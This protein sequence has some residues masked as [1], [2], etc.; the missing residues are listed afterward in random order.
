MLRWTS[1][2]FQD[3]GIDSSRLAAEVLLAHALECRRID[4]YLRFDQP[5]SGT[6]RD[7][8]RDLVRRRCQREPVAYITGRREFWSLSLAVDPGVLIPRP[9]TECL[10]EAILALLPCDGQPPRRVLDLG[11]GSGAV[12]LALASERPGYHFTATD[13]SVAALATAKFN[14]RR[15]GLAPAVQFVAGDWFAPFGAAARWDLVASNPPYIAQ[16]TLS[17]LAPEVADFEP[18]VALDGGADGLVHLAHLIQAAP[19]HLAGGGWLVLEIGHDQRAAV[20][21]LADGVGAYDPVVFGQDYGGRDR[22]ARLRR[23]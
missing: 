13:R 12:A 21:C 3:Q 16:A 18:R 2:F 20:Q 11:T 1:G 4:L 22:V 6:E 8:F 7:R 17:T 15:L 10:V 5:L 9:D 14:A 19:G 23:R